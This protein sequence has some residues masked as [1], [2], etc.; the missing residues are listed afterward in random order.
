MCSS[1]LFNTSITEGDMFYGRTR[2]RQRVAFDE[3]LRKR[4]AE[5][6]SEMHQL[7]DEGVTPLAEQTKACKSCS[8]VEICLPHMSERRSVRRYFDDALRELK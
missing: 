7:F 4:V 5:L 2:R 1:D 3:D 8:L 6:A